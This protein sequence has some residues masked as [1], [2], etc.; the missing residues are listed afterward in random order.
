MKSL[1]AYFSR[2]GNNYVGGSIVDL[3]VGNT[4]IAA[5]MIRKLTDSDLF[6]IDTVKKYSIDYDE[7]TKAAKA[8]LRQNAR[9]E[10]TAHVDN[11]N[12]YSLIFL[13]YPNWW[14]TMPMP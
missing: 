11:I 6:R 2:E 9:P 1:I 12:E 4:E 5:A 10:L 13:G 14:G 8:E 3:S 7:T